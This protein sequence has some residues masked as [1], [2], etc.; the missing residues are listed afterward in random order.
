MTPQRDRAR[1]RSALLASGSVA[2]GVCAL[3]T[4]S[5]MRSN[6]WRLASLFA[7][8]WVLLA[9]FLFAPRRSDP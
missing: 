9:V 3:A 6:D 8:P 2:L 7:L 1:L 5:L 4:L